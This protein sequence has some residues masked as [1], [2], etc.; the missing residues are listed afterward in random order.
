[1]QISKDDFM[2]YEA[3]RANGDTNM[4]AMDVVS[5]LSGLPRDKIVAIMEQYSDLMAKYPEVVKPMKTADVTFCDEC[6][7]GYPDNLESC[8]NCGAWKSD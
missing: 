7:V 8:P 1:M 5:A 3:V 6:G 4:F 2:A